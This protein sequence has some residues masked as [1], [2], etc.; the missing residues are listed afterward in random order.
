MGNYWPPK[1]EVHVGNVV[2]VRKC[3]L[4]PKDSCFRFPRRHRPLAEWRGGMSFVL[5]KKNIL[6]RNQR[7]KR[8][9]S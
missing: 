5:Q 9:P 6:K 8:G 7:I 4:C 2:L 3:R 1:A